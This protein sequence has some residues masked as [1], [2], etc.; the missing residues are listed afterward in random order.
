MAARA[1]PVYREEI[2]RII[3]YTD[4][5]RAEAN[6]DTLSGTTEFF[7]LMCIT[8]GFPTRISFQIERVESE[9]FSEKKVSRKIDLKNGT[10]LM[11]VYNSRERDSSLYV[12]IHAAPAFFQVPRP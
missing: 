4:I 9:K 12:Y 11:Q 6:I 7:S 1:G 8:I 3:S 5:P 2:M 10:R